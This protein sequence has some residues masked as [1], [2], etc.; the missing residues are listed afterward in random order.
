MRKLDAR[1]KDNRY[2]CEKYDIFS[3]FNGGGS[4]FIASHPMWVINTHDFF[5]S[6]LGYFVG[7][8]NHFFD[9]EGR[10]KD[11]IH[12]WG[13]EADVHDNLSDVINQMIEETDAYVERENIEHEGVIYP[14]L[15]LLDLSRLSTIPCELDIGVQVE[16]EWEDDSPYGADGLLLS[17]G[18]IRLR[19]SMD[20]E[21]N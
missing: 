1:V 2:K 21:G 9:I 17:D 20:Q 10:Y 8:G 12:S 15:T 14:S 13:D 19:E 4:V 3:N 11:Y 5:L 18:T 7:T 6:E 16:H